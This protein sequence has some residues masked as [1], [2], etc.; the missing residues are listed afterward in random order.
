MA[1]LRQRKKLRL[2]L[3]FVLVLGVL[4]GVYRIQLERLVKK[5][6]E[7]YLALGYPLDL[8]ELN[9][10][11]P[12][13]PDEEN[14]ALLYAAASELITFEGDEIDRLPYFG[15]PDESE[16]G[17]PM[18]Q[19]LR[20]RIESFL[21]RNAEA[22]GLLHEAASYPRSRHLI[23]L[24]EEYDS[25]MT[26]L[27]QADEY[28]SLLSLE[29]LYM[30][31]IGDTDGAI[32]SLVALFAVDGSLADEPD[33]SSVLVRVTVESILMDAL[34]TTFDRLSLGDGQLKRL[35]EAIDKCNRSVGLEE[36]F[37]VELCWSYAEVKR[38]GST[39]TRYWRD[40]DDSAS[41]VFLYSE[42][43]WL[44]KAWLVS[45]NWGGAHLYAQLQFLDTVGDAM[46]HATP[47]LL[48][49]YEHYSTLTYNGR[50]NMGRNHHAWTFVHFWPL[51]IQKMQGNEARRSVA[52]TALAV[53]RFRLSEGRL[54]Y[55]LLELVPK[56]LDE[57]P[58]DPFTGTSLV[59][60]QIDEGYRVYSVG[61]NFLDEDGNG[62]ASGDYDLGDDIGFER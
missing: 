15:I 1:F 6:E 9:D 7:A 44:G 29:S 42:L 43:P 37:A 25:D 8:A 48:D 3:I 22:Y 54:P 27:G 21:E 62:S 57:V 17:P 18:S 28:A 12:A 23:D 55:E 24:S 16:L 4:F 36:I 41:G 40:A 60:L 5:S 35:S 47:R 10:L 45:R 38:S 30:S 50:F 2:F 46:A 33:L 32:S 49:A 31:E 13:V 20:E 19:D 34:R 61:R 26:H 11:Y 58:P 56:F 51:M 59:Y 14:G 39:D 52:Q 53:E